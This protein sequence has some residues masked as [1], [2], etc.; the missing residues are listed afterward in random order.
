[1]T[2]LTRLRAHL[3]DQ[4]IQALLISETHFAAAFF[5]GLRLSN[6]TRP[7]PPGRVGLVVTQSGIHVLANHTEAA[8][9]AH[10]L[11][12]FEGV[13][14][15][16]HP[17]HRWDLT[18]AVQQL[19]AT[20]GWRNLWADSFGP[21]RLACRALLQGLLYPL[22]DAE[23]ERLRHLG[24]IIGATLVS[25]AALVREP[26]VSEQQVAAHV[27]AELLR[28]GALPDLVFVAFDE[29]VARFC[30]CQP[31]DVRLGNVASISITASLGGLYA[32]ATRLLA[33]TDPG[34]ELLREVEA[35]NRIEVAG[36]RAVQA[37]GSGF[38][39]FAA[40][41]EAYRE[42]GQPGG[43]ERHHLGGPCG[44]QGRDAKVGPASTHAFAPGQ[45]FVFNPVLGRG[46]SEDT[47]LLDER[48]ELECLTADPRWPTHTV[49]GLARPALLVFH[50]ALPRVGIV[51]LGRMGAGAA[52][53]LAQAGVE[54]WAYDP[55]V[56]ALPGCQLVGSLAELRAGLAHP[57]RILLFVP[58]AAVDAV[59]FGPQG[60]AA[61]CAPGDV[62]VDA[63]NSHHAASRRRAAELQK[64][65]I[66]YL[67]A[68]TSG[69]VLGARRGYCIACG[70]AAKDYELVRPVLEI[71]AAAGACSH[72]GPSG[73]GHFLKMLHNGLEYGMLQ[74]MAEAMAVADAGDYPV[75]GLD[76][77]RAWRRHSIAESLLLDLFL[78]A[79]ERGTQG[80][81]PVVGGGDTGQWALEAARQAGVPAPALEA[82]LAFRRNTPQGGEQAARLMALVRNLFGG[83]PYQREPVRNQEEV[84]CDP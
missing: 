27:H 8:R 41:R 70:G 46:K 14:V 67:D 73:S 45:P 63:G 74:A 32:S 79:A 31:S 26:D 12:A 35:A 52:G 15:H 48:G 42:E 40:M 84:K 39:V 75:G 77:A 4:G 66:G 25:T 72:V 13:E 18:D 43:W 56:R 29:R 68:G 34:G 60:L 23:R 71:M 11:S 82:A 30:H 22:T 3:R 62:I 17:W 76:L 81:A 78:E 33:L 64:M 44:F 5:D 1:M 49:E 53:R 28:A 38:Q 47:F 55:E 80:I 37:G 83:H 2:R 6:A 57:A 50:P 54:L 61:A 10:D 21:S 58:H 65:G 20:M 36:I 7:E 19:S 59:L 24:R 16:P 51:G 69:G 9:V